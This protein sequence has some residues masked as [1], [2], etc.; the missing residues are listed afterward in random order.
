MAN[1]DLCRAHNTPTTCR[2]HAAEPQGVLRY[3]TAGHVTNKKG[4]VIRPGL[5]DVTLE[6]R[7][8]LVHA[9]HAATHATHA[10]HT[11]I[12]HATTTGL[13]IRLVTDNSFSSQKQTGD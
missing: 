1:V 7:V 13:I 5:L 10:A 8:G 11:G 12:R 6:L 9:A 4:P 3:K 2:L